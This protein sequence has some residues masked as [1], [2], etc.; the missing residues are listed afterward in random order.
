MP[1]D[2][3]TM[4]MPIRYGISENFSKSLIK[5][6]ISFSQLASETI[7]NNYIDSLKAPLK[8]KALEDAFNKIAI[9]SIKAIMD[10]ETQY[11]LLEDVNKSRGLS[12][13]LNRHP[14]IVRVYVNSIKTELRNNTS[15]LY[16][17]GVLADSHKG[18]LP[19]KAK[20]INPRSIRFENETEKGV[21]LIY[22]N[23]VIGYVS[24]NGQVCGC[25]SPELLN[26]MPKPNCI[27]VYK[28]TYMVI[29]NLGRLS[30]TRFSVN[31]QDRTIEK[32]KVKYK[33]M[34]R[35]MNITNKNDLYSKLLKKQK[36][37]PAIALFAET[38]DQ[39]NAT[40]VSLLK[41]SFKKL[42]KEKKNAFIDVVINYNSGSPVAS[43]IKVEESDSLISETLDRRGIQELCLGI[44][45]RLQHK[46]IRN[47]KTTRTVYH[48]SIDGRY[49]II[50][51][52]C[53]LSNGEN[54]L[55]SGD[56]FY[57]KFGNSERMTIKGDWQNGSVAFSEY[58][59]AG[60][61]YGEFKGKISGKK[62]SG[63]FIKNGK[64]MPFSMVSYN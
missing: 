47:L 24:P 41:K 17:W 33:D 8:Y 25:L 16:Y 23:S 32:T 10:Q 28:N 46:K 64:E 18:S 9:D 48:G 7:K 51:N 62:L 3:K 38:G 60:K 58:D 54:G 37:Q 63:V 39:L 59:N 14:E 43:T 53:L 42:K 6:N 35:A 31:T 30:S 49:P 4:F 26:L 40:E 1:T 61:K 52:F 34:A 45:E 57:S 29:D 22:D 36:I 50:M 12:G 44:K 21:S 27:Y 15:H 20:L 2:Q 13:L 5:S 19:K 56:Y 55:I 11:T